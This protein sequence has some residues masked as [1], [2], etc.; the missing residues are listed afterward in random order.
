MW[1]AL[2][3]LI[4]SMSIP[5]KAQSS[6]KT[7]EVRLTLNQNVIKVIEINK[8]HFKLT[9]DQQVIQRSN[10]GTPTIRPEKT[11]RIKRQSAVNVGVVCH[12]LVARSFSYSH[13]SITEYARSL[14]KASE[15]QSLYLLWQ[16]ESGWNYLAYNASSGA[17][18]IPQALPGSKM[19]SAGADWRTNPRTQI[20]WGIS[21]IRGRYGTANNAWAHSQKYNWY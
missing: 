11:K 16:K 4:L 13:S 20:R 17:T 8:P 10:F 15:W 9:F 3:A 21:Y 2:V 6:P 14:V 18:G 5:D 1:L 12:R 19:A 7:H